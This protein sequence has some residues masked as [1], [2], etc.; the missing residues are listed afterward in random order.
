M[1]GITVTMALFFSSEP[2]SL[3]IGRVSQNAQ[4]QHPETE[5]T[6]WKSA[7]IHFIIYT[8]AF[9]TPTCQNVLNEKGTIWSSSSPF[10]NLY[11]PVPPNQ[12]PSVRLHSNRVITAELQKANFEN[13][14]CKVWLD[15]RL[16]FTYEYSWFG[17]IKNMQ[18]GRTWLFPWLP[19]RRFDDIL[20][21]GNDMQRLINLVELH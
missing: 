9:P 13:S 5:A 6:K 11:F 17:W 21:T 3:D 8:F 10:P 18:V 4:Y 14:G 16:I 2:L 15:W 12:F 1:V 19:V 20:S 7:T